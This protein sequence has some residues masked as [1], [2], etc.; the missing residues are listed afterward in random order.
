MNCHADACA[1]DYLNNLSTPSKIVPFIPALNAASSISLAGAT[2]ARNVARQLRQA[3]SSPALE[4]HI[5]ST[6][7]WNDWIFNSTDWGAQEK[8]LNTLEHT[9]ELFVTKWAHNLLLTRRHMRRMGRAESDL[10]P[11]C[12]ATIETAPHIFACPKRVPWQVTFLDSLRKLLAKLH[13]QPDLQTILMV[14]IQGA[15][16][17][18]PLFDMPAPN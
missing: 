3:A 14:G 10:C 13:K 2:L 16:Q 9:Q 18:D 17:D 11:S 4:N 8:A 5:M 12:L 7:G 1:T 6:H 15:L